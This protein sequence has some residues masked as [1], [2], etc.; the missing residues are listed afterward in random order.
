MPK[1]PKRPPAS[2]A[3]QLWPLSFGVG[4]GKHFWICQ[5]YACAEALSH[6]RLPRSSAPECLEVRLLESAHV[7]LAGVQ[8]Y[9]Q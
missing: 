7:D 6:K 4:Q 9:A 3:T 1:Q 2:W 5:G 8:P